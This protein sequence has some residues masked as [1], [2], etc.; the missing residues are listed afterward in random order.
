MEEGNGSNPAG[1]GAAQ[2]PGRT[3][4]QSGEEQEEEEEGLEVEEETTGGGGLPSSGSPASSCGEGGYYPSRSRLSPEVEAAAL[5]G[6]EEEGKEGG[7]D[8]EDELAG[9]SLGGPGLVLAVSNPLFGSSRPGSAATQG[10][11]GMLPR[12]HK[13]A[14]ARQPQ[15]RQRPGSAPRR[16]PSPQ[17]SGGGPLQSLGSLGSGFGGAR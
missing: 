11:P 8:E 5:S 3:Q 17:L 16:S 12:K 2:Q 15:P 7:E 13:L 6:A 4:Q 1:G 9:T 10:M 14:A